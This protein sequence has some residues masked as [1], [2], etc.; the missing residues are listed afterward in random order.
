MSSFPA[1]NDEQ[2]LNL[3]EQ[4]AKSFNEVTLSR[5]FNSFKQ[6]HVTSL[7]ISENR[8]VQAKV[9]GPEDHT[10]TVTL[11]LDNFISSSCSC[12]VQTYCKHLA[13][14][15]M[16][17][18]DRLGYPASQV[19]N[20]AYH[21]KR[22]SLNASSDSS[23]TS[24]SDMD[25]FNWHKFLHQYTAHVKATYDHGA[26]ANLL[27]HE[28]QNIR[29]API[30]FSAMDWLFFELHQELFILGKLK[31]L[32]AQGSVNYYTSS[33]LYRVFD[34]VHAWLQQ[35]S[36]AFNFTLAEERLQ[37]TLSYIRQQLA[38]ETDQKY[39]NY[40]LYTSLWKY[41]IDPYPE[42]DHWVSQEINYIEKQTTDS[43]SPSLIAAKAF[44]FLHQSKSTE[45]WAVLEASGTLKKAPSSL[46]LSFLN[47]LYAAREWDQLLDWLLKTAGYFYG[48]KT[49]ELDAYISYWKE[50][51]AYVPEADKHLWDVLEGMLPHSILIIKDLLYEQRK[52]KPWLELQIL[53][54]DDP[55]S[56]RVSVLQPIEKESPE[57]LL[58]YYHQA[59]E[60]YVALKNRHDYKI[61]V[62]L[63]KR[64]D[65]VYKK[66]KQ[67]D[68]WDRFLI[69]FL[70]RHSRLRALQEEMKKGKLLE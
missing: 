42:A 26:F 16:E 34:E 37:Q 54:G 69:G 19:V 53:Q 30:P 12:P 46:L 55:T 40:G 33:A 52:W 6:Q 21:L 68:R 31:E 48:K 13:A 38:E 10:D 59:I 25:I 44:L 35:K 57:L 49:R 56:H 20:A 5:G 47:Q 9:T 29:K 3:L 45:A 36:T 43:S 51:A 58:P 66:M 18:A 32:A 63:L 8:I 61:A 4:V 65:K 27:R 64:L 7:V 50:T 28:M 70:E 17:L 62:K 15:I 24:L 41:W 1:L 22:S 23:L 39:L 11:N 60:R 2:W 14:V 67:T